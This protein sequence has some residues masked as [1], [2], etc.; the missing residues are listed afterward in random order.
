MVTSSSRPVSKRC[1]DSSRGSSDAIPDTQNPV[2][3]GATTRV[4]AAAAN[5]ATSWTDPR[6]SGELPDV[7]IDMG[8]T[9]ENLALIKGVTRAEMDE[10][11]LRSQNL[12]EKA[13]ADGFFAREITP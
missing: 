5:G 13:T 6:G 4:A 3:A 7:Y 2:F 8:Q 1:P 10:F 9:A 11:A 12:A